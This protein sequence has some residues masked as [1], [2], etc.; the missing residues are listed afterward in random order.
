MV[1]ALYKSWLTN[2]IHPT[3]D[4]EQAGDHHVEEMP[5]T[6][7]PKVDKFPHTLAHFF[8]VPPI[9][10]AVFHKCMILTKL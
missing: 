7:G 1:L 3:A 6:L 2:G 5:N 4:R 8:G 9:R 10:S